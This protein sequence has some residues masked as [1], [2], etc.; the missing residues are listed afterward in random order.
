MKIPSLCCNNTSSDD[1]AKVLVFLLE[2][3]DPTLFTV[4][5]RKLWKQESDRVVYVSNFIERDF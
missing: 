2:C 5:F 1:Q 4:L 3:Y